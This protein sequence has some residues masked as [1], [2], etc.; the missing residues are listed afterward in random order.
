MVAMK[1]A[2][3][4]RKS[5][6][7]KLSLLNTPLR[8]LNAYLA[9]KR[10]TKKEAEDINKMIMQVDDMEL[11]G[12]ERK[13]KEELRSVMLRVKRKMAMDKKKNGS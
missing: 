8:S 10:A 11:D 5:K 12:L 3:A 4:E 2:I 9:N 1:D 7:K 13:R 6:T